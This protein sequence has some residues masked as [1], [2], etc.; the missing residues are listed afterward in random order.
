MDF[1][2]VITGDVALAAKYFK[3]A[4]QMIAA[5]VASG[6][7]KSTFSNA[8][9]ILIAHST[10]G[11]RKVIFIDIGLPLLVSVKSD[12]YTFA[13][14]KANKNGMLTKVTEDFDIRTAFGSPTGLDLITPFS[15]ELLHSFD[16][17]SCLA[18]RTGAALDQSPIFLHESYGSVSYA[19]TGANPPTTTY[20]LYFDIDNG[21]YSAGF[22]QDAI[23][24][25]G[26]PGTYPIGLAV[27]ALIDQINIA[28]DSVYPGTF[29]VSGGGNIISVNYPVIDISSSVGGSGVA[30]STNE[31]VH[32]NTKWPPEDGDPFGYFDRCA[33]FSL[34][35]KTFPDTLVLDWQSDAEPIQPRGWGLSVMDIM[36]EKRYMVDVQSTT[37]LRTNDLG[38]VT[39]IGKAVI[40]EMH[41]TAIED[42]DPNVARKIGQ[43]TKLNTGIQSPASILDIYD[44]AFSLPFA[45][46]TQLV[47]LA[48]FDAYSTVPIEDNA[49]CIHATPRRFYLT[50]VESRIY[51]RDM[52]AYFILGVMRTAPNNLILNAVTWMSRRMDGSDISRYVWGG[53][54]TDNTGQHSGHFDYRAGTE[55]VDEE[56]WDINTGL[57]VYIANEDDDNNSTHGIWNATQ[58]DVGDL[59]ELMG[60]EPDDQPFP[61]PVDVTG[62]A[63]DLYFPETMKAFVHGSEV[64]IVITLRAYTNPAN[65]AIQSK[66]P[67]GVY[68][69]NIDTGEARVVYCGLIQVPAPTEEDPD[70]KTPQRFTT[71]ATVDPLGRFIYLIDEPCEYL[72]S[73]AIFV[74]IDVATGHVTRDAVKLP[75][76]FAGAVTSI[77]ALGPR[78]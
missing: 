72:S 42:D 66:I 3:K 1:R 15:L 55:T 18:V 34:T 28:F 9:I 21:A 77:L 70:A 57:T 64:F 46:D 29:M 6:E 35:T 68:A 73:P 53:Y 37:Y 74:H 44:L 56:T 41:N 24:D 40:W 62:A 13:L 8:E 23:E 69:A 52:L 76:T 65:R 60:L 49:N 58:W 36:G 22:S 32:P 17:S 5:L 19:S 27:E 33:R 4:A 16:R 12:T 54:I 63:K 31:P 75:E 71:Q 61:D 20:T 39:R 47:S 38:Y 7:P 51:S 59:Y 67:S 2:K 30:A 14:W 10:P 25:P 45:P 48:H 50:Y 11:I 78:T 43:Y 26:A